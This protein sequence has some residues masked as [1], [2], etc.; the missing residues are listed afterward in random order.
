MLSVD[1]LSVLS[2]LGLRKGVLQLTVYRTRQ[3]PEGL[4]ESLEMNED[5]IL[6]L[7]QLSSYTAQVLL[8]IDGT[9]N[10]ELYPSISINN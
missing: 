6:W 9:I 3:E 4:T 7:A 10:S 1:K 5:C 8:C 2:S